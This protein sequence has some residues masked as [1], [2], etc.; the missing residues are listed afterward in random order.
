[1]KEYMAHIAAIL[2][3]YNFA[4]KCPKGRE[5]LYKLLYSIE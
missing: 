3:Q 1:M 4:L 2:I 5:N